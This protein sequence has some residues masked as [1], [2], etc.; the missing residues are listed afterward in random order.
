MMHLVTLPG[1]QLC[2]L[3]HCKGFG[4][5]PSYVVRPKGMY[6]EV[7]KRKRL[8]LFLFDGFAI[9]FQAFKRIWPL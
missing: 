1:A 6:Q 8:G 3:S 7:A 4:C 5:M 2:Y 9:E